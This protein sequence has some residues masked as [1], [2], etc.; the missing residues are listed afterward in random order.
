[1]LSC[2]LSCDL[3]RIVDWN[4]FVIGSW[5]L[6][7]VLS[8][9]DA[10]MLYFYLGLAVDLEFPG[11]NPYCDS[12]ML[13]LILI[14]CRAGPGC[15]HLH[16][17]PVYVCGVLWHV[18][19]FVGVLILLAL[20][21]RIVYHLISSF[22]Y[23]CSW[24]LFLSYYCVLFIGFRV[25]WLLSSRNGFNVWLSGIMKVWLRNVHLLSGLCSPNITNFLVKFVFNWGT[26]AIAVSSGSV[27]RAATEWVELCLC[28]SIR[29]VYS[30]VTGLF[31][32]SVS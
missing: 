27:S 18:R 17:C 26:P 30:W 20:W 11:R 2:W 6:F 31:T 13:G 32:L 23:W 19:K 22:L 15:G 5:G 3:H 9:G 14:G 4:Y 25:F 21:V 8:V 12:Y 10:F 7:L 16:S 1:M 24:S 29:L 28:G